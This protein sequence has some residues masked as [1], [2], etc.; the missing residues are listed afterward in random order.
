[1]IMTIAAAALAA[2]LGAAPMP[3]GDT[4]GLVQQVRGGSCSHGYDIDIHGRCY[5]N[6]V[7]PPQYQAARQ[8]RGYEAYGRH[9]GRGYEAYGRDRGRYQDHPRDYRRY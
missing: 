1:M 8:H 6:G 7:I 2:Q 4:N 3:S 9:G 5:P